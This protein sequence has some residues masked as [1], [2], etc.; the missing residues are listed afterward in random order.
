MA[1]CMLFAIGCF[2][3][4]LT[5]QGRDVEYVLKGISSKR[6]LTKLFARLGGVQKG[7]RC[8]SLTMRFMLFLFYF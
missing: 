3:R 5:T 6:G 1:A 4:V 7:V 8:C 2:S